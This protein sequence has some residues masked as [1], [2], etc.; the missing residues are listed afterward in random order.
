MTNKEIVL[1][2]MDAL[3]NQRDMTAVERYWGEPYIQHNVWA[4]HRFGGDAHR[5]LKGCS[6]RA[7]VNNVFDTEPPLADEAFGFRAGAANPRGRQFA[8]EVSRTF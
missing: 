6:I 7:S 1:K 3:I 8:L 5:W 4:S 2:A